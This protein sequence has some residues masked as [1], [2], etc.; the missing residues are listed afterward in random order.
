VAARQYQMGSGG[1]G[2][3]PAAVSFM[4]QLFFRRYP[5]GRYRSGPPTYTSGG[6][7]LCN[8]SL[9][10][11]A[12]KYECMYSAICA[13][14]S[15]RFSALFALRATRRSRTGG[16]LSCIETS[17][18]MQSSHVVKCILILSSSRSVSSVEIDPPPSTTV[19]SST[20]AHAHATA[21]NG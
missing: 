18:E 8:G 3:I 13:V 2:S 19:T 15:A 16:Q 5:R 1:A 10:V 6:Q 11:T 12:R 21:S 20:S 14:R 4:C 17:H 9:S 7:S